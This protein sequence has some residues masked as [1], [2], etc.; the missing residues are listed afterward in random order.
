MTIEL[1][2]LTLTAILTGLLWIPAVAGQIQGRGFLQPGDYVTLPTSPLADWAVRADRAHQN[3]V[4]NFAIFAAVV[5][6][7]NL[8]DVSTLAT[9]IAT[10]VYFWARL[11]H[12]V[13]MIVGF[14]YVM[15]RTLIF[16]VGWA[17]F[18]TL[19]F[20]VLRVGLWTAG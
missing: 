14:K 11:T 13:V 3:A 17:A 20:E 15:A 16:A 19:G 6:V 18:L 7:A 12:A 5:V 4:E 8:I 2:Y 10:A 9:V 1:L